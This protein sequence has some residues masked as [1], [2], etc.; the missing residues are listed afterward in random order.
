MRNQA[1]EP[2]DAYFNTDS[3]RG[4]QWDGDAGLNEYLKRIDYRGDIDVSADTLRR[5]H[6]CHTLH[7]PFE[8]LDVYDKKDILLDEASLFQ[9]IV[10]RK[11]GGYCFEV[12][13]LFS[14]VLKRI[15]F[16]VLDVLARPCRDGLT[17][18]AKTH[19]ALLVK[20]GNELWLADVGYGKNG[21]IAPVLLEPEKEQKQFSRDYRIL[22]DPD[23]G[24][25]LQYRDGGLF[26]T[27]YA[28]QAEK[29]YPED[30]ILSN[31]YTSTSPDSQFTQFRF[32]TI[33]TES[34][35]IT[36]ADRKLTVQHNGCGFEQELSDEEEFFSLLKRYF[37]MDLR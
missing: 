4:D 9:K 8:N 30:F 37:G 25:L 28:F 16:Q 33:P 31:Y 17:F 11:R 21:I 26:T 32:C 20:T 35:R 27:M 1:S 18:G 23:F 24:H 15:G 7:V 29:S 2:R 19:Q 22:C 10:N 13:G 34:G 14:I 12:N 6:I 3:D 36:L 5:M